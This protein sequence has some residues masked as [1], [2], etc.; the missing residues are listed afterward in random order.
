M[1]R[2]KDSTGIYDLIYSTVYQCCGAASFLMRLRLRVEKIDVAFAPTHYIAL[3]NFVISE[4]L[5]FKS[6]SPVHTLYWHCLRTTSGL[7]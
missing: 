7:F 1:R 4:R 5:R 3:Q 6:L 2:R